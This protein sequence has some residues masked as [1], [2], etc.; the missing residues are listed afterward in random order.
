MTTSADDISIVLSGGVANINP[1]NSLGGDPSSQP[2]ITQTLNNLFDDISSVESSEGHEDYRCIYIFNDGDTTIWS[3][4]VWL[5]SESE[6]SIQLGIENK[7]ETQRIVI[8]SGV[9]GGSLTLKYKNRN[10]STSYDSDLSVW[11][12]EMQ[13]VIETLT[14]TEMD[15]ETFFKEATVLAQHG[16]GGTIIFDIKWSGSDSKRNFDKFEVESNLLQPL[17]D[18]T[19]ALTVPVEGAPVNTIA[20]EIDVENTAPGGVTFYNTSI[21]APIV[22][23]RLDS[24]DGFPLWVKRVVDP[25]AASKENDGFSLKISA[26]SLEP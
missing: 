5:L 19:V 2:I 21:S 16:V 8:G 7:N 4:K 11:A 9:N 25:G 17:G 15:S 6:S 26:Q 22:I 3:F 12:A 24:N 14:I 13:T 10:F 23:P 18:I 20:N 1:N